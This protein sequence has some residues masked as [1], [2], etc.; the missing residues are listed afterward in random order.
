MV[1]VLLRTGIFFAHNNITDPAGIVLLTSNAM[2]SVPT[3]ILL[4]C[5]GYGIPTATVWWEKGS[6]TIT[7]T[8]QV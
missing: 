4:T 6:T 3:T 7:N 8:S 2:I 5:V 1:I